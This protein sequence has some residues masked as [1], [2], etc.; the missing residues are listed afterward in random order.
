MTENNCIENYEK[1][2]EEEKENEEFNRLYEEKLM[3]NN[4]SLN[5]EEHKKK[6]DEILKEIEIKK[7]EKLKEKEKNIKPK[8]LEDINDKKWIFFDEINTCNSMGL[9]SEI[10]CKRTIFG[11]KI[12]DNV[13]FMQLVI[14][15]EELIKIK[16]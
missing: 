5:E 3:E 16:K 14:L 6:I 8:K 10:M 7:Q 12:C 9:I 15:I 11:K 1:E 13:I 4:I 2:I